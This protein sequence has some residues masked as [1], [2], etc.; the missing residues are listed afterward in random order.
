VAEKSSHLLAIVGGGEITDELL[1]HSE[2]SHK[3]TQIRA[4]SAQNYAAGMSAFHPLQTLAECP[5]STQSG[6]YGWEQRRMRLE[7]RLC[8]SC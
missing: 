5:L 6:R 4:A 2:L 7:H 1:G 8:C 3:L